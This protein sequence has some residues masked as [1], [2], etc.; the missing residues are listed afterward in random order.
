MN[1]SEFGK[2]QEN[3]WNHV[4]VKLVTAARIIQMQVCESKFLEWQPHY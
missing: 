1:N 3:L 4:L 2:A